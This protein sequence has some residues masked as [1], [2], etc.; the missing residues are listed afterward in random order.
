VRCTS[1]CNTIC[2]ESSQY[3]P[4]PLR[5]LSP[6]PSGPQAFKHTPTYATS[7]FRSHAKH[8]NCRN[9]PGYRRISCLFVRVCCGCLPGAVFSSSR[10]LQGAP[11]LLVI[12]DTKLSCPAASN[13]PLAL[14][15]CSQ[16]GACSQGQGRLP[17]GGAMLIPC[18]QQHHAGS[19][20]VQIVPP[21]CA[22]RVVA[23]GRQTACR[24][25]L[26][27]ARLPAPACCR[28]PKHP[29]H[30]VLASQAY[31]CIQYAS[32]YAQRR[33]AVHKHICC[34]H[35]TEGPCEVLVSQQHHVASDVGV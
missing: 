20:A 34:R 10:P 2:K 26:P 7:T 25:R 9:Q 12:L 22:C 21:Q 17:A 13:M 4:A 15:G 32:S 24:L 33:L 1:P 29:L 14:A 19:S 30:P 6:Q 16:C 31:L 8:S 28:V 27:H 11:N 5:T 18:K 3:R 23:G 35:L